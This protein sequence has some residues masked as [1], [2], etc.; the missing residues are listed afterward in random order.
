MEK[1]KLCK[2]IFKDGTNNTS[3]I[4][5]TRKWIELVNSLLKNNK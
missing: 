2:S 4:L 3:R 5:F 1:D